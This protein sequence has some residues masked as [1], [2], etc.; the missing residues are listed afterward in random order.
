MIARRDMLRRL[1]AL[2]LAAILADP[3]LAR[4]AAESLAGETLALADGSTVS[5]AVALPAQRPAPAVLLIHEW[6]GLNDQIKAVAAEL[7]KHGYLALAVDLF[8]GQVAQSA[9]VARDLTR[10]TDPA[11]ATIILQR[12][13]GWLRR[14][15]QG[16]GEVAPIGWCF[17][18][19]WS[20]NASLAAPVDATVVYYGRVDKSAAELAALK[21][22][23]LGHF[24]TGD[25]YINSDMVGGFERAMQAAGKRYAVYWYVAQHAF[26]NPTG[27]R[28][29][30]ADA[31]LA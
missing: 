12:W 9:D 8:A 16:T 1:A 19:G 30:A 7:A 22:P 18:G 2:P 4:A 29:D 15:P 27:N 5:A 13:I 14:H 26:A 23:V 25:R 31:A 6:W 17:G 3:A 10:A 20:L 21:G 11:R 28:Y 24:A